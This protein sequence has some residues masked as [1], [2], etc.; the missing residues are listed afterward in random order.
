VTYTENPTLFVPR[1][2]SFWVEYT[3]ASGTVVA[4]GSCKVTWY[5]IVL[6][7]QGWRAVLIEEVTATAGTLYTRTINSPGHL[8]ARMHTFTAPGATEDRI[9]LYARVG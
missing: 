7:D 8:Y 3:D 4:G 1:V 9:K 2:V 5:S 6:T